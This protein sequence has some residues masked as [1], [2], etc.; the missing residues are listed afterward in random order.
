MSNIEYIFTPWEWYCEYNQDQIKLMRENIFKNLVK[1]WKEKN[2][3]I[4]NRNK[5]C[6]TSNIS[7][8]KGVQ[9]D[10]EEWEYILWL[11]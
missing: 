7:L 5:S 9:N 8:C 2:I 4:S 11:A 10:D 6:C 3:D 1:E